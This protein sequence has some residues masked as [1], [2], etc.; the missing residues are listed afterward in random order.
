[1][2]GA[3]SLDLLHRLSTQDLRHVAPGQGAQTVLASDKGRIVD[4]LT[5]YRFPEHL[6]LVTA[7]GNQGAVLA[8]LDKYTISEDSQ[9]ADVTAATAMLALVGPEAEAVLGKAAGRMVAGMALHQHAQATVRGREVT[10]ARAA[11]P[12]G[13]GYVVLCG[14]DALAA[15]RDALLTGGA[16]EI[17]AAAYEALR[18]EAGIPAFGAELGEEHNPLE[19]GLESCISFSKGCYIGQE[20]IARLDTYQKVQRRLVALR[21]P[22]GPAPAAG[23]PLLHEGAIVGGVTSSAQAPGQVAPVAMAYVRTKWAAAGTRLTAAGTE[24]EVVER[25]VA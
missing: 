10:L 13:G 2:T 21:L 19:A 11:L 7:P 20:V 6:L 22:A 17:G 1:M 24:V 8:Y 12:A 16:M 9:A 4:L 25:P 3:D 15:V 23:T 18:I 5:V 14:S